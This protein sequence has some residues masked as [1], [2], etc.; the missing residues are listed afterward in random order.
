MDGGNPG[1]VGLESH[2][3]S[4]S[5]DRRCAV[6][7]SFDHLIAA[8]FASKG[9]A[10]QQ[11]AR[12]QLPIAAPVPWTLGLNPKT[13]IPHTTVADGIAEAKLSFFT[14]RQMESTEAALRSAGASDGR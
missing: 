2:F 6:E 14:A 1:S 12:Q 9:M 13:P 10:G 3:V 5:G 11:A 4:A 8:V 7:I